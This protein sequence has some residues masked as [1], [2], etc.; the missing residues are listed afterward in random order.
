[1]CNEHETVSVLTAKRELSDACGSRSCPRSGGDRDWW[2]SISQSG[3]ENSG[4]PDAGDAAC[5]A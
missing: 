2:G 3:V 5:T 1:M 4:I